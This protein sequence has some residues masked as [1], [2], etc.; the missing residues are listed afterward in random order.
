MNSNDMSTL[1]NNG[2]NENFKKRSNM[3]PIKKLWTNPDFK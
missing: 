2:E 3:Y 1:L